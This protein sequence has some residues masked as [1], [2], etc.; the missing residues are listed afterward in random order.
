MSTQQGQLAGKAAVVTGASKGIGAEIAKLFA[1]EGAKVVVN[2]SS[3]KAGADAVVE[4]IRKAGGTAVAL[5]ADLSNPDEVRK[6]FVDSARELGKIDILVNNAGIYDFKPLE[7]I[8]PQ[9]FHQQFNLNVLGL[10]LATQEAAKQFGKEGGSVINISSIA[11]QIAVPTASVYAATKAA[12]DS[13]TRS[14]AGEL[15]PRG[16]RVNTVNPGMV[17]TEGVKSAG[18]DESEFRGLVESQTPLGRIGQVDD[19]APAALFLASDASKWMTGESVVI[20]GG[21]R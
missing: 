2:Y 4:Q 19:I 15:G 6:L 1:A 13:I 18:I 5:Q 10:L 12:V 9:H 21:Y 7:E 17:V 16:I 3:S 20:S 11:S 8:T 14:L